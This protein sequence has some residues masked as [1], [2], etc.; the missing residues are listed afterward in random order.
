MMNTLFSQCATLGVFFTAGLYLLCSKLTRRFKNPLMNPM[1]LTLVVLVLFLTVGGLDYDIYYAGARYLSYLLTPATVCLAVPLYRQIELLKEHYKAICLGI[2]SGVLTSLV[3][4][5]ALGLV[6]GISHA[7]YATILPKSVTTPIGMDL[8]D[9]WGGIPSLT[10]LTI[11]I[12]GILGNALTP[13]LWKLFGITEPIAR[14]I[15]I[16]TASH[17]LGTAKAMEE[18]EIEGAMSGLSIAVAGVLTV[19][20]TPLF[21]SLI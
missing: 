16:G 17:A 18:G 14:G 21:A 15:C 9:E 10:V 12:S 11:T 3:T 7:E 1:I 2:L 20:I 13:K 19:L 4:V 5:L 8:A 6:F